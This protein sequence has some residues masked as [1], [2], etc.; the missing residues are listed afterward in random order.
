MSSTVDFKFHGDLTLDKF[1]L[2]LFGIHGR[3]LGSNKPHP[4]GTC[5][6]GYEKSRRMFT[7]QP[8]TYLQFIGWCQTNNVACWITS[9]PMRGYNTPLGIEKIFFDFDYHLAKNENMTPS[10]REKVKKLVLKF[11]DTLDYEPLLVSTR[12]GYHVYV[13]LRR[14]YE[15]EV[16]NL[17]FA[18]EVFGV[19]GLSLLGMPKLYEQLE[20]CE[21][22]RW[23]YL[24][25][26]PL[27][28]IMRMARVPLTP[29]EATG[30]PCY[31]LDRSLKPTKVRSLDLFKAYGIREDKVR[32]AVEIVKKHHENKI[33]EHWKQVRSGVKVF[34][35]GNGFSG[36][37]RPCFTERLFKFGEMVHQQRLAML[38][39]AWASGYKTEE[40]LMHLCTHFKEYNE[41]TSRTQVRWFLKNK[42]G[43]FPPYQCKTIQSYGWCLKGECPI[44]RKKHLNNDTV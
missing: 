44:Y 41:G 18:S 20:E 35:G 23:K 2:E 6:K 7:N 1:W 29:H 32:E 21:R 33:K 31:I 3:E 42:A 39:E 34:E 43:K 24:D 30:I 5:P 40:Q 16:R 37:M 38:M 9:Q 28:D 8:Q 26:G 22:K 36:Q 11:I 15:F 13:F 27:G 10:K 12:K 17:E 14:T 4:F 25:F 19:I